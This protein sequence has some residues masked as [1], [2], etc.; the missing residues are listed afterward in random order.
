MSGPRTEAGRTLVEDMLNLNEP[1]FPYD[2]GA[3]ILAIEAEARTKALDEVRAAVENINDR[4]LD[5]LTIALVLAEIDKLKG[6][7][8][9]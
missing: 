6:G 9:R 1:N 3:T 8:D 4:D 5:T 7:P 2:P